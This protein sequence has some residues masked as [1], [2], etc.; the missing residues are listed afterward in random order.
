MSSI[1]ASEQMF[2]VLEQIFGADEQVRHGSE[3]AQG[4]MRRQWQSP[5]LVS[6]AAL[7]TAILLPLAAS[8][9]PLTLG[10]GAPSTEQSPALW[11]LLRLTLECCPPLFVLSDGAIAAKL[12][13]RCG[14]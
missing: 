5:L 2:G 4:T 13:S 8:V 9:L 1:V 10:T 12:V 6:A 3:S 11:L 14:L 7:P